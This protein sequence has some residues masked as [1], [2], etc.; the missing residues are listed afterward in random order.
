MAT[1][2]RSRESST[3]PAASSLRA[4]LSESAA[5]IWHPIVQIWKE[6]HPVSAAEESALS[7]SARK[8]AFRMG[9]TDRPQPSPLKVGGRLG[10][11]LIYLSAALH[12]Q[13]NSGALL[14]IDRDVDEGGNA[15]EVE[16]AGRHIPA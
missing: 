10:S 4:R 7:P 12:Q 5:F 14:A 2:A 6:R 3:Y 11:D 15:D 16:A 1:S 9:L 13:T 8:A